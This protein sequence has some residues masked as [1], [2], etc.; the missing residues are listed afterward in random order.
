MADS[1]MTITENPLVW[2][3]QQPR[4]FLREQRENKAWKDTANQAAE[5]LVLELKRF[6]VQNFVLSCNLFKKSSGSYDTGGGEPPDVGVAVY[7][8]RKRD[9]EV[10][11]QQLLG[12]RNPNPLHSEIDQAFREKAPQ[13]HPEGG[14]TPN[15][16]M[17]QQL[18]DAKKAAYRHIAQRKGEIYDMA[19]ACDTWKQV[20]WNIKALAM[21]LSALRS[22][23]RLGTSALMERMFDS[24][25]LIT[26][27]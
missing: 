17:Y 24:T 25:A 13:F 3:A 23:E 4:T 9:N 6:K 19:I 15:L 1:Q 11:W 5:K 16:A 10:D 12:I 22:L 18:I 2:P 7:F 27:G 14:R 20:R 21:S 26:N 8:S